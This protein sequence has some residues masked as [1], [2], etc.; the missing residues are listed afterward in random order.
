MAGILFL[1]LRSHPAL[2]WAT[3]V[4]FHLDI[5]LAQCQAWRAA[6]YHDAHGT[7][8]GFAPGAQTKEMAKGIAH[9]DN[10]L[11]QYCVRVLRPANGPASVA[12]GHFCTVPAS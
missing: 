4:Q 8:V 1:P 12:G 2:S 10:I 7:T 9:S 3:A 5:Y 11:P 6:I